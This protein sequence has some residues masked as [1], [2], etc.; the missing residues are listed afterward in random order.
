MR[1][2]FR[3]VVDQG[4][5][6]PEPRLVA[7]PARDRAAVDRLPS[8]PLA[9]GLHN[10]RIGFGAQASVVPLQ[11]AGRDHPPDDWFGSTSQFLVID[12]DEAIRRQHAPPMV[13]EPLI[14]A[15]I[16]DQFGTSGRK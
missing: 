2:R 1:L 13:G 5:Q 10:T 12:L 8:L 15:E 6:G 9:G 7:S 16:C 4:A 11:T 3:R 14:A